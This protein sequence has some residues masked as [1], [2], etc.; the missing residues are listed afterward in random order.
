MSQTNLESL[1]LS[2]GDDG[3]AVIKIGRVTSSIVAKA[4]LVEGPIENPTRVVLDRAIHA[5]GTKE[6]RE[7]FVSGVVS[8]LRR[9]C[10][11][12]S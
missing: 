11:V 5:P 4:L 7:W 12:T 6:F 8:D 2:V 3:D 9:K 10:E 1:S